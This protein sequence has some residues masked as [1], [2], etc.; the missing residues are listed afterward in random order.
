LL[1]P[2][3]F[4]GC[5]SQDPSLASAIAASGVLS[6]ASAT[7]HC[8]RGCPANAPAANKIV[9]HAFYSLSNNPTTKFADWVA[10]AIVPDFIGGPDRPRNW[11]KDPDLDEAV[12]L[13]PG[14]YTGFSDVLGMDRGHQ[15]PLEAF[16]SSPDW[17]EANYLSNITP[18]NSNLNGGRWSQLEAAERRL[19]QRKNA[20][21]YVVTGPLYEKPMPEL[22]NADE[23]HRIPSGYWKVISMRTG[24]A[25][26]FIFSQDPEQGGY[27]A[28]IWPLA[29]IETRSHLDLYPDSTANP[30]D[31]ARA[32]LDC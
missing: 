29:E 4:I 2:R 1:S 21:V 25:I 9:Q 19:A 14:D 3:F 16:A 22:P 13:E 18:Q 12:T 26:G 8:S 31:L 24:G 15:A 17:R 10:Y 11:K 30:P 5:T 32:E 6:V 27:C 23:P 7:S 20:I 28:R